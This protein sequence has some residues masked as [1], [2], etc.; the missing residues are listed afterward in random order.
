[1]IL[2]TASPPFLA[3]SELKKTMRRGLHEEHL[4]LLPIVESTSNYNK[5][6]TNQ[7]GFFTK[8]TFYYSIET[9]CKV[10][11]K[12]I[13]HDE[14]SMPFLRKIIINPNNNK[15]IFLLESLDK[16]NI[17]YQPAVPRCRR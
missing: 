12:H 11:W 4:P 5:R 3:H 8:L 1:M 10:L 9:W 17:N 13:A 14:Y 6:M 15:R 2:P 7:Q 16:M